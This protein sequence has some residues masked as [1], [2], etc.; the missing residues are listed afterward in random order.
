M[1][2]DVRNA[3]PFESLLAECL[4]T[5]FNSV[6]SIFGKI[7][8]KSV[9]LVKRTRCKEE[10]LHISPT[11]F[12]IWGDMGL[13][14]VTKNFLHGGGRIRGKR[15]CYK[16]LYKLLM[17]LLLTY[18]ELEDFSTCQVSVCVKKEQYHKSM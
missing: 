11:K 16:R 9:S 12:W 15:L 13:N 2:E 8:A 18:G 17:L 1:I 3:Y 10:K 14:G 5:F 7:L 4:T 6:C